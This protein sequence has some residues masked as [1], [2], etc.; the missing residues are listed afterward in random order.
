MTRRQGHG[1]V[2]RLVRQ[3]L[4]LTQEQ[5]ADRLGYSDETVRNWESTQRPG[6]FALGCI[7][8]L[9]DEAG[10]PCLAQTM[11]LA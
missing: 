1:R 11:R 6:A 10:L 4:G 8:Q 3:R 7:A 9:A 2:I 5:L